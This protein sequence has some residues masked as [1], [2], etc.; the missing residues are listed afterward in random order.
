MQLKNI[1]LLAAIII[2]AGCSK[3][4]GKDDNTADKPAASRAITKAPA[5]DPNAPPVATKAPPPVTK[6]AVARKLSGD[7]AAGE[8]VYKKICFACHAVDG[9][10]NGGLTGAD[11]VED[12]TR[13]AKSDVE[14][15]KSVNEGKKGKTLV[16]PPQKGL[17]TPKQ[18]NDA[19]AYIRHKF[20][21]K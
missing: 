21:P 6:P 4:D 15:F 5:A 3:S 13:L 10:G 11:L 7:P 12:K 18:I 20:G 17:L 19:I 2:L 16:M 14:L 8:K 9:R 1:T